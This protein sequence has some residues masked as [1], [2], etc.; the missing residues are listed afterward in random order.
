ML[1][2]VFVRFSR[3][4]LSCTRG[5]SEGKR[6]F[7]S[8]DDQVPVCVGTNPVERQHARFTVTFDN[9]PD[10]ACWDTCAVSQFPFCLHRLRYAVSY[11]AFHCSSF[12]LHIFKPLKVSNSDYFTRSR[13]YLCVSVRVFAH[14]V[15]PVFLQPFSA[16]NVSRLCSRLHDPSA[17]VPSPSPKI[18]NHRVGQSFSLHVFGND[19]TDRVQLQSSRAT[20]DKFTLSPRE[21]NL[22]QMGNPPTQISNDLLDETVHVWKCVRAGVRNARLGPLFYLCFVVCVDGLY[23]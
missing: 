2:F 16:V 10:G 17:A 1:L 12:G 23:K 8:I 15:V 22:A 19:A 21:P 5:R 14:L 13:A 20:G 4:P 6:G 11:L 9:I 18:L 7:M 3:V